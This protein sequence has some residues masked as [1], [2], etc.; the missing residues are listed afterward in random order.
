[1]NATMAVGLNTKYLILNTQ[2]FLVNRFNYS[3]HF[4]YKIEFFVFEVINGKGLLIKHGLYIPVGKDFVFFFSYAG[5]QVA[6]AV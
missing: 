3:V 6:A 5:I 4:F 2:Y 1:M